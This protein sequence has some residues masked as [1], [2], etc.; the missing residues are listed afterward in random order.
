L[1]EN[2]DDNWAKF[3]FGS[4]KG[5]ILKP[6]TR[7]LFIDKGADWKAYKQAYDAKSDITDAQ[8]NRVL[9]FAKLVTSASDED[10]AARLPE[11]LDVDEFSRF[12]AVTVWLSS[13][14][15][16]L[17]TAQNYVVYL[18]PEDE[19]IPV[20]PV[21]SGPGLRKLFVPQPEELSLRKAWG[22]DIR[23]L[24]RV[25]Q[26]P[27]M[28]EAYLARLAEFKRRFSS[29]KAE[30]AHRRNGEAHPARS[31]EQGGDVLA[32]SIGH[33]WRCCGCAAGGSTGR[34]AG[35]SMQWGGPIKAFIKARHHLWPIIG[36]QIGRP[37]TG[38]RVWWSAR[39]PAQRGQWRWSG[40]WRSWWGGCSGRS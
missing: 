30:R 10:F 34:T 37:G 11:Y 24:N 23:F 33:W 15:S 2:L 36:G 25:M 18:P 31:A 39:R 5:L 17:M 19:Q 4:K 20:C 14:D 26:A 22:E 8:V 35:L 1:V 27:V 32:R 3:H 7:E 13:T 9:D 12:M 21:G 16:I 40:P 28:R 29:R 38:C 6:V